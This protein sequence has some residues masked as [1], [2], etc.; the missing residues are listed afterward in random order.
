MNVVIDLNNGNIINKVTKIELN[1]VI[2]LSHDI[3]C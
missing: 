1:K 2:S 3:I